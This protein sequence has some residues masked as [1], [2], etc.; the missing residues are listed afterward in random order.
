MAL[1]LRQAVRTL[2]IDS[3]YFI[4]RTLSTP[5]EDWNIMA[6]PVFA[7][8]LAMPIFKLYFSSSVTP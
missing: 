2:N 5:R 1:S 4:H 8:M 6:L 7:F 3:A